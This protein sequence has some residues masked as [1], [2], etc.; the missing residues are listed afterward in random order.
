MEENKAKK[1]AGAQNIYIENRGR[2][3]VTEVLEVGSFNEESIL[4]SVE[5]NGVAIKGQDLHIQRLDLEEGKVIITG[6]I[7]SAAYTEKRTKEEGGLLKKLL[8]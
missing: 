5:G 2:V 7:Q 1:S 8:K 6:K 4:L 3:T